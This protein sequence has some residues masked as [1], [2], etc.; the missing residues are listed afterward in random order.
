M[1]FKVHYKTVLGHFASGI[2]VSE[3]VVRLRL[4][5]GI[6]DKMK[7]GY[8]VGKK[9]ETKYARYTYV[10]DDPLASGMCRV[11]ITGLDENFNKIIKSG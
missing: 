5:D 10:K 11:T 4:G 3:S 1:G 2:D 9:N 8:D 6:L 7:L